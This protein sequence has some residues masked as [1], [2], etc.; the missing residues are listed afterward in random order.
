[1]IDLTTGVWGGL[2]SCE[3]SSGEVKRSGVVK[4]S[5]A[6]PRR[7]LIERD[8]GTNGF[9]D[10]SLGVSEGTGEEREGV[11]CREKDGVDCR[12][13]VGE[14]WRLSWLR[15]MFGLNRARLLA[16]SDVDVS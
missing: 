4:L 14:F 3:R 16:N 1:M 2:E 11:F 6:E 7:C 15:S 5:L 8:D 9:K 12:V 10:W 13:C